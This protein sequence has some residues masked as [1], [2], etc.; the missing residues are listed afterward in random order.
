[1]DSRFRVVDRNGEGADVVLVIN[2]RARRIALR[3][4]TTRREAVLTSPSKRAAKEALAFAQERVGWITA[5]LQRLP[6]PTE[7]RPGGSAP[8]RGQSHAL[9][10]RTGGGR[11]AFVAGPPPSLV[12]PAPDAAAF[13]GRVIRFLKAEATADLRAAVD[14]HAQTLDVRPMRITVKDTRSRWGSCTS[15][16]ALAFSWRVIL[17]PPHVLDY[18]AAHEVAHLREMNHSP[19]FWA[20]VGQC[21]PQYRE[22]RAWLRRHG[23]ALHAVRAAPLSPGAE[24]LS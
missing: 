13:A 21:M 2:R 11:P 15:D 20:L 12:V 9:E 18:L 19:R 4:D 24:T 5:Q 7:I 22:A 16:G 23:A 14:R 6:P 17:A 10:W 1:M 3:I 8:I